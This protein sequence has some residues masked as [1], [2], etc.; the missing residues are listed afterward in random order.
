[1]KCKLNFSEVGEFPAGFLRRFMQPP[2][3]TSAIDDGPQNYLLTFFFCTQPQW[4]TPRY[5]I[6]V[7]AARRGFGM[8]HYDKATGCSLIFHWSPTQTTDRQKD[9]AHFTFA[10][11]VL[12]TVPHTYQP[13]NESRAPRQRQP[14]VPSNRV[15]KMSHQAG[16][17]LHCHGRYFCCCLSYHSVEM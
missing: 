6:V 14:A 5:G 3:H 11:R 16:Q 2:R 4:I 13:R 10:F 7:E 8:R 12:F 17:Q 15:F 1:M 9:S